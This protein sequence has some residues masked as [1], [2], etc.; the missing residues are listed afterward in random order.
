MRMKDRFLV[1]ALSLLL[2]FSLG[3][4]PLWWGVLFSPLAEPLTTASSWEEDGL[5]WKLGDKVLRF[6]SLD[7]LLE[8]LGRK[9]S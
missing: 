7:L 1:A 9:L 8:F 5:C 2:V 6:R 4:K 3:A